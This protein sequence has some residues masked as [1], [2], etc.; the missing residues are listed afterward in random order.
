MISGHSLVVSGFSSCS[1]RLLW[2]YQASLVVV[3]GCS[4][5]VVSGLPCLGDNRPLIRLGDMKPF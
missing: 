5:K 4:L 1:N 3:T 2:W